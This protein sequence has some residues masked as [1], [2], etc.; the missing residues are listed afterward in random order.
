MD[1]T[2]SQL[3]DAYLEEGDEEEGHII[4]DETLFDIAA[5]R[6]LMKED[7]DPMIDIEQDMM[8]DLESR[9][10]SRDWNDPFEEEIDG[11]IDQEN[12][13]EGEVFYEEAPISNDDNGD[14]VE[15]KRGEDEEIDLKSMSIGECSET[16]KGD[17]VP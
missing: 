4:G 2:T 1:S 6:T 11:T 7:F 12:S 9:Y 14:L 15:E 10:M 13:D 16:E 8:M 17:P 3:V 5:L